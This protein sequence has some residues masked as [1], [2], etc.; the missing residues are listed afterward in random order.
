MNYSITLGQ[1]YPVD[2]VLHRLDPRTKLA[3]VL[4]YLLSLFLCCNTT[5]YIL[6]GVFLAVMI[7]ISHVPLSYMVRGLKPVFLLMV[8]SCGFHLFLTEGKPLVQWTLPIGALTLQI[9]GEGIRKALFLCIRLVLLV[10]GSTLL[11]LTTTPKQLTD[12]LERGLGFLNR[13][14]IPIHELAMMMSIALRFIPILAEESNKIMKAQTARGADFETGGLIQ[15]AKAMLPIL[16]PLFVSAFRRAGELATAMDARCYCGDENRTQ[17][18]P[19]RYH[20]RDY[21]AVLVLFIYML[22]ILALRTWGS[23]PV[24]G[25]LGF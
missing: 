20:S 17:M 10:L 7:G 11:T 18:K 1:Y 8:F 12:G 22:G 24:L 6:A 15:R 13:L 23:L 19:L 3:S 9:T 21:M 4:L 14:H 16:V 5:S 2:S 25:S